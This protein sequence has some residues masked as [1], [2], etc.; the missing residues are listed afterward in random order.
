MSW[1]REGE[2]MRPIRLVLL[3]TCAALIL[4]GLLLVPDLIRFL[5]WWVRYHPV[6]WIAALA[7]ATHCLITGLAGYCD[8]GKHWVKVL[9]HISKGIDSCSRDALERGLVAGFAALGVIWLAAWLPHYLYWPWCR[10]VD[11]FAVIAQAWDAGELPYRDI[12][13]Y[14]FPGHIYLHWILGKLFGWGYAGVFYGVDAI[15]LFALGAVILAWSR[16]CLGLRLPGL[17]SYLIFLGYYLDIHFEIVAERDWHA[18]LGATLGLLVLQAWPGRR[19]LWFSALLTGVAFTIRP[20]VVLFLP[21]L[22]ITAMKNRGAAESPLDTNTSRATD[23]KH[24]ILAI[25]EWFCALGIFVAAG[26]TPLLYF[27]LLDDL[28][29]GLRV[30]GYSGPYSTTSPAQHRDLPPTGLRAKE[31]VLV[32]ITR[33]R[34]AFALVP[35]SSSRWPEPGCWP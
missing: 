6:E 28:I 11:T 29:S 12:R 17:T 20:H 25:L 8:P 35:V 4:S 23:W 2:L 7:F 22:A 21:A 34:S 15:A 10:D 19:A 24:E 33:E 9:T 27:G 14:N 13:G 18:A 31:C 5:P 26:F 3:A 1:W 30:A 16:R 32:A